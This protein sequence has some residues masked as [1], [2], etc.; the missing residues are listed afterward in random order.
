MFS[1][2][3]RRDDA[4][5]LG[6]EQQIAPYKHGAYVEQFSAAKALLRESQ[7]GY[8]SAMT[9]ARN[10]ERLATGLSLTTTLFAALATITVLPESVNRWLA[11]AVAFTAAVVSGVT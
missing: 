9:S 3:R 6:W 7:D 1:R 4:H 8:E 5:E 2:R 11:A 10:Q